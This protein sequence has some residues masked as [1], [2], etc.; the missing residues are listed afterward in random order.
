MTDHD[1]AKRKHAHEDNADRRVKAEAGTAANIANRHRG[2]D[3]GDDSAQVDAAAHHEGNGHAGEGGV[4][5]GR[6][7]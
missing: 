3:G 4:R 2:G 5:Q 7:L 1:D 6:R